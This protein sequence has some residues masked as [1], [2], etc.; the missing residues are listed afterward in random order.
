MMPG[1]RLQTNGVLSNVGSYGGYWASSPTGDPAPCMAFHNL[2][3]G[4]GAYERTKGFSVR[5]IKD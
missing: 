3:L 4:I 5:C 2:S 1:F